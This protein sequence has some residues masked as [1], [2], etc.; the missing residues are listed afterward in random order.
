MSYNKSKKVA[1]LSII[2]LTIFL[3]GCGKFSF[4]DAIFG[5]GEDVA[6]GAMTENE[7]TIKSR[8]EITSLISTGETLLSGSR[9]VLKGTTPYSEELTDANYA[10]EEANMVYS[11]LEIMSAPDDKLLEKEQALQ[12]ITAYKDAI[13]AYATALESQ[14]SDMVTKAVERISAAIN[15]MVAYSGSFN[16]T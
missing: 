13:L 10:I 1:L 7:W 2:G 15:D 5:T 11:N 14:D 3:T 4:K 9:Y 16:G 12:S 6:I 8:R